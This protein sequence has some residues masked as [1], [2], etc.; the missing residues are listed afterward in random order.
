MKKI[1]LSLLL[2]FALAFSTTAVCFASAG[3]GEEIVQPY[4]TSSI[5]IGVDRVSGT[6]ASTSTAA[7][8]ATTVDSY[9]VTVYLQKL[10]NNNWVNDTNNE[11]YVT[12]VTGSNRSSVAFNK[13]YDDLTYG[14]SYRLKVVSKTT[15][16]TTNYT[17]SGYSQTF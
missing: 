17:A 8:F 16:G 4:A 3:G 6:T 9:T 2:V 14:T 12:K 10:S 15:V 13:L 11:D 7:N 1:L 5:N